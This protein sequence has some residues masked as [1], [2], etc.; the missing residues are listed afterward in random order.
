MSDGP[1]NPMRAAQ[2]AMRPILRK[3]F[4]KTAS[5]GET[6]DGLHALLLDG[7]AARTPGRLKI[8]VRS[9]A[10]AQALAREWRE[11]GETIDPSLMPMTRIVNSALDGVAAGMAE[12][13]E[14]IVKYAASDLLCYRADGPASLVERQAAAHDPVLDWARVELGARFTVAVGVVAVA[15]PEG[16]IARLRIALDAFDDALA[17][18]ALHVMTTLTGSALLALAVARGRLDV[19]AAWRAAHVDEDFQIERWG[20]D[21]EARRRREARWREMRAAAEIARA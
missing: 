6:A 17:L 11:Q 13:R 9:E 19:E 10:V 16:S 15:Q 14:E 3:R 12:T 20:E 8:A 7:R 1:D 4:Y 21:N 18:A 2:L 5:V